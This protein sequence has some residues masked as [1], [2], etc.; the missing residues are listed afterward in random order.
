MKQIALVV[1]WTFV[2]AG[3]ITVAAGVTHSFWLLWSVGPM[4]LFSILPVILVFSGI[5]AAAIG[6]GLISW[7]KSANRASK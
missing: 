1:G 2:I 3:G 5:L 7:I 4:A 6:L